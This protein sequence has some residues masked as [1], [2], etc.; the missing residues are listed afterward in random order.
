MKYDF[1]TLAP[2][3]GVDA[4]MWQHLK[5]DGIEDPDVIDMGVAE[6]KFPLA[7]CIRDAVAQQALEGTF[8]YG[9]ADDRLLSAICGWMQRHH[10]W[11]VEPEWIT[12]TYGLVPA[13]GYA[14]RALTEPNDGVLVCFPSYG[15]FPRT[16]LS[17]GRT[18]IRSD[19]VLQDG[20]YVMD[21]DDIER[22]L[23]DVNTKAF[24]LCNP[25]NPT[26]RVWTMD[27]LSKLGDMCLKYGVVV[28]SDDIHFDLVYK[29]YRHTVFATLSPEF[30]TN[31]VIL[32][33]PSKT[34]NIAGMTISNVIV[35]DK[36]K[37]EKIQ[38]IIERDMGHYI[39]AFGL[40]ACRVAYES[41]DKWLEEALTVLK[42]NADYLRSFCEERLPMIK[43]N[44]QQGTYLCWADCSGLNMSADKLDTFI[45][46]NA[47]FMSQN[48]GFFGEG[49][50]K[51]QRINVACPRSYLEKALL[52]LEKAVNIRG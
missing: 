18:L 43:L 44:V 30:A 47:H 52:R 34:F 26:G 40:V 38:K 7:P 3:W 10:N 21:W 5:A 9:G 20:Q 15:P 6:M 33:A 35:P 11:T 16:V 39:N 24:I 29:P 14:L 31:S 51:F 8:G 4:T 32:T 28:I 36:E 25:H 49:Y 22:K 27:E 17:N 41:G 48:G 13:I 45:H 50:E 12:Q 23:S 46:G 1:E 2:R 42:G 37:R 19:L